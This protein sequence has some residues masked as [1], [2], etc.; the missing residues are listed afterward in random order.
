[1]CSFCDQRTI[2]QTAKLPT[3]QEI[4]DFCNKYLPQNGQTTEIAF[5]G[6][7]FTAIDEDLQTKL[8]GAAYPFVT[9]KKAYGIRISTRPDAI[10]LHILSNLKRFGVT[11]IELG[12][13]SMNDDILEKNM[14]GHTSKHV[15]YAA[16]LIKSEGFSLGLQMMPGLYGAKNY[17]QEALDTARALLQLKPDTMRVYPAVVIKGTKLAELFEKGEYT[18]LT[19]DEAAKISAKIILM[20]D[21]NHTSVIRVGLN[22]DVELEKAVLSGPYHPAFRQLC[23]NALFY[24]IIYSQLETMPQGKYTVQ[25]PKGKRSEVGGQK[26]SNLSALAQKGYKI[27]LTENE[28]LQGRNIVIQR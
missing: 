25:I 3:P 1:M 26:N 24:D 19:L 9:E 11:S 28:A 5:F 2:S 27:I 14:R 4:S 7:S 13:Q 20:C 18:P 6:G 8:L 16:Q 17:E 21:Q 10:N 12:A 15:I 23:E 22:A